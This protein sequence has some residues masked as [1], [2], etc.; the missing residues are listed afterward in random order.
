MWRLGLQVKAE[1]GAPGVNEKQTFLGHLMLQR[2]VIGPLDVRGIKY[3][4]PWVKSVLCLSLNSFTQHLCSLFVVFFS[5]SP[6]CQ[7]G[8]RDSDDNQSV[9]HSGADGTILTMSKSY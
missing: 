3:E 2:W 8:F 6:C 9:K 1:E 4:M 7:C 5:L